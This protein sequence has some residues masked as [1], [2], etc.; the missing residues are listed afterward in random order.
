MFKSLDHLGQISLLK[1]DNSNIFRGSLSLIDLDFISFRKYEKVLLTIFDEV[2]FEDRLEEFVKVL[3]TFGDFTQENNGW[4]NMLCKNETIYRK[5]LTHNGFNRV[6]FTEKTKNI[7]YQLLDYQLINEDISFENIIKDK[8]DKYVNEEKDWRYYFLMYPSF[9]WYFNKGYYCWH[10]P[11]YL[12]TKMKE[13]HFNGYNWDPFLHDFIYHSFSDK[14][15]LSDYQGKL[16]L[17]LALG[18]VN[19]SSVANGF[20]FQN[21]GSEYMNILEV[22]SLKGKGVLNEEYILVIN[23]NN[24][25]ID[26]EDRIIKLRDVL[27]DLCTD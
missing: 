14:L 6:D 7:I 15:I 9:R 23:Q 2:V 20:L 25:G 26:L 11:Q 12:M 8:L 4:T 17:T 1:I 16:E 24:E 18:V 10:D 13:K 27:T 3:L 21:V 19:I 5:F 22:D